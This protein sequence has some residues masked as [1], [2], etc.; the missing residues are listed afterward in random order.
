MKNKFILSAIGFL[1]FFACKQEKKEVVVEKKPNII[2]FFVDDMGWQDTSVPFWNKRTPFNDLY[3]TPNMERLAKEGMKFTQA[4]ATAVCSPTR[5]SL[6][7]G[8]NAARH[9]VTNWTLKKDALQPMETNHKELQFP[10]WNVNGLSPVKGIDKAVY[11]TPL[12]QLLQEAGYYTIH[13]GKAHFGAIGTPGA[14]PINL[15]F[16]VNIA[17]HAAGAPESYLGTENFGNGKNGK[18]V[19][20]VPGLEK[21]H[22]KDIFL[23]EALTQEALLSVDNAVKAE[24]PFF[25]YMAHYAIHTPLYGDD[26]Y[27][28]K[29]LDIGLD[30]K[31]AKYASMIEGMDKSLGDIMNYLDD[32]KL[33]DNTILLFMSDNGG[34]SV[35]GRGGKPNTHN[36]PLNSG[37]GSVYEGGIREPMLVKWP[38]KVQPNSVTD[39]K[40]IIEDFYPTILEI[41]GVESPKTV[42]TVDGISFVSVLNNKKAIVKNRPLFWHYPNEWGPSGPGIGASSA[43]RFGDYKLVY[44]HLDSRMELFNIKE[45]IG[46]V[47]N[48]VESNTDKVKELAKILSD[49]LRKVDAQMPSLKKTG[50]KVA[51]PDAIVP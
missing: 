23:T 9:R 51:L 37:K 28:Q 48:L 22:G 27:V 13:S 29:Y 21:Y 43:V 25:L 5:V 33:S 18:E 45:D 26:R 49:H 12:P 10:E 14:N 44:Y 47:T 8:M 15:G 2:L 46:E 38:E 34:L 50:I 40:V 24:Q 4:Y 30:P 41:A 16:D 19:W 31:E 35:H 6:M 20:A 3:K 11:A 32:N 39:E 17:G 36:K 1:F 42:Q 7:T